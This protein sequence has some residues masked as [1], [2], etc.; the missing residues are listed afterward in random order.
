MQFQDLPVFGVQLT[1]AYLYETEVKRGPRPPDAPEQPSLE[2]GIRGHIVDDDQRGIRV[3]LGARVGIPFKDNEALATIDCSVLGV[4]ASS[5][6][7]RADYVETFVQ[8]E[9][10][11]LLY[12]YLRSVVGE[13]GRLI[14][15]PAP[16]LPTL[17]VLAMVGSAPAEQEVATARPCR[18]RRKTGS[19]PT[20]PPG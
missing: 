2:I 16:P 19:P 1:D 15:L 9:A 8:R 3:V 4:F 11:V 10:L 17:D 18:Q 13:L 14:S 12:P 6:P 20:E 5:T 7:I